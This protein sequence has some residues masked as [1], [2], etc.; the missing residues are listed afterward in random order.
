MNSKTITGSYRFE[1]EGGKSVTVN[2]ENYGNMIRKFCSS[3]NRRRG[4]ALT[5]QWFMQD[6][7]ASHTTNAIP[8]SIKQKFGD[9]VISRRTTYPRAAHSFDLNPLDV[10]KLGKRF[11]FKLKK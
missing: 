1:D 7:S 2:Q 8:E 11:D 9:I 10:R 3:L 5:Q 6:G 4:I